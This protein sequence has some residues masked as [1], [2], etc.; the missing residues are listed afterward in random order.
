MAS[1]AALRRSGSPSITSTSSTVPDLEMM[2]IATTGP[3]TWSALAAAGYTGARERIRLFCITAAGTLTDP[4]LSPPKA[5]LTAA[6]TA[7]SVRLEIDP[8]LS[9]CDSRGVVGA[10]C[11]E[12]LRESSVR[13][14]GGDVSRE[15]GGFL[16]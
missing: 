2:A 16:K 5:L 3:A 1:T 15:A 7:D 14:G 8:W 9:G 10:A 4:E 11:S 12:G 13:G 6:I